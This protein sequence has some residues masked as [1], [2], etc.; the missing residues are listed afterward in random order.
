MNDIVAIEEINGIKK[1]E[2][3]AFAFGFVENVK[4]DMLDIRDKFF[5]IGFRLDEA[6]RLKYYKKLGFNDIGELAEALFDIKKTTAYD[7]MSIYNFT[8][9]YPKGKQNR[10]EKKAGCRVKRRIKRLRIRNKALRQ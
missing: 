3:N 2:E 4:A 9:K 6:A 10:A 7:L 8:V 1:N 5:E